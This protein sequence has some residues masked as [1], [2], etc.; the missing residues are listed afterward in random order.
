MKL[1]SEMRTTDY[2]EDTDKDR[3]E[4]ACHSKGRESTDQLLDNP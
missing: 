1:N 2:T 3:F 4:N